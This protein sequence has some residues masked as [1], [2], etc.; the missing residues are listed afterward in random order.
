MNIAQKIATALVL[1]APLATIP[2]FPGLSQRTQ[3]NVLPTPTAQ[4]SAS[5]IVTPKE[6]PSQE[7]EEPSST[8]LSNRELIEKKTI[9]AWDASQV[10]PMVDLVDKESDFNHLADNPRST[11]SGMFQFIDS[12]WK[13]QGCKKTTDPAIQTDCGIKYIKNRYGTPE[14]ALYFWIHIAPTYDL[15]KDGKADGKNW[16]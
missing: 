11:A 15:N 10:A 5:S 7:P 8:K 2:A 3:E 1:A 14:K 16:Y 4:A 9:E 6:T 12:T 13:S